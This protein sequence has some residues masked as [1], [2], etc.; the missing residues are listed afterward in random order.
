MWPSSEETSEK[1]VQINEKQLWSSY[2]ACV[3]K[4][5]SGDKIKRRLFWLRH[6]PDIKNVV[7]LVGALLCLLKKLR[8]AGGIW[9]LSLPDSYSSSQVQVKT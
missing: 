6:Y 4:G 3:G 7:A 1:D 8:A 2:R 9:A 5:Q